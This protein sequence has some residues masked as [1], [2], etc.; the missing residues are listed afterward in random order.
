M[1]IALCLY[2]QPRNVEDRL[3][4][5]SHKEWKLSR[6][7]TDVYAHTW[8][9]PGYIFE[10]STWNKLS[11]IAAHDTSVQCIQ[12]SYSPV[13]FEYEDPKEFEFDPVLLKSS[14]AQYPLFGIPRNRSNI[15]SQLYSIQ[16]VAKMV[17]ESG[18]QYDFVIMARYDLIVLEF[19]DLNTLDSSFFYHMN[20]HPRFPDL[21]FIFPPKF[22]P[23]QRLFDNSAIA[24]KA[25]IE[26]TD[27]NR[28]WEFSAECLKY[29]VY[30]LFFPPSLIRGV[31]IR[32]KRN[33]GSFTVT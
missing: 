29:N 31:F 23:S 19:P 5:E 15:L 30:L 25:M 27:S 6:Y 20:H 1:K 9:K 16:R 8:F 26:S 18:V 28:F 3:V 22:L 17:E 32:E 24:C 7:D 33:I 11:P 21:F 2:G 13:R 10:P 12:E 14:L 4:F